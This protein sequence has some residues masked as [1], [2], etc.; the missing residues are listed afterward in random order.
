MW[1]SQSVCIASAALIVPKVGTQY[2]L[3]GTR[4]ATTGLDTLYVNGAS[5][6]TATCPASSGAGWAA[7]TFG[8]GYGMWAGGKVDYVS[9]SIAGVGLIGRALTADEVAALYALGAPQ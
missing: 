4:D 8:L 9:G 1:V 3:V 7:T 6:A 2:H 5:A